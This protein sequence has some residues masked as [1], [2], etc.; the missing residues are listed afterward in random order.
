MQILREQ[1]FAASHRDLQEKNLNVSG[2]CVWHNVVVCVHFCV[3]FNNKLL[4]RNKSLDFDKFYAITR[5]DNDVIVARSVA[6]L[7]RCTPNLK[8]VIFS[9]RFLYKFLVVGP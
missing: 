9:K 1:F 3:N 6:S 4:W 2:Y 8:I 7:Y 5:G